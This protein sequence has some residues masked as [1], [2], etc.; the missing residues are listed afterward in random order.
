MIS[1]YKIKPWFQKQLLPVLRKLHQWGITAN[2]ITLAAIVLS[3][4]IGIAFWYADSRHFLFLCLPIGLLIRMML[5]AL[6]GMMAR[7]YHQQ[8][9]AGE[10]LNELG[11][12]ISD[13]FVFFSAP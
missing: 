4:G 11:D 3:A 13:F 9:K 10:V 8:S 5:N 2:Q 7:N 6:D 1:I 12:V